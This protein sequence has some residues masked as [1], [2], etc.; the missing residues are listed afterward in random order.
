M[1]ETTT[2]TKTVP[3][4]LAGIEPIPRERL[5][6]PSWKECSRQFWIDFRDSLTDVRG[7]SLA[8]LGMAISIVVATVFI[9]GCATIMNYPDIAMS[10]IGDFTAK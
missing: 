10:V 4:L 7:V 1:K 3:D 9:I 2:E 5:V 8:V 6:F